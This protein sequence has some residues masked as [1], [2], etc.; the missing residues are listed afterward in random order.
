MSKAQPHE[1]SLIM[2][3]LVKHVLRPGCILLNHDRTP[4]PLCQGSGEWKPHQLNRSGLAK[5]QKLRKQVSAIWAFRLIGSRA[6]NTALRFS[7]RCAFLS[8]ESF[9]LSAAGGIRP[10]N[11]V[12][13]CHS[14]ES[15]QEI[16]CRGD[17]V[18]LK[19][20]LCTIPGEPSGHGSRLRRS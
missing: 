7:T 10:R 11:C 4:T 18:G 13:K 20:S 6:G 14:L 1:F 9:C 3:T 15:R 5:T 12:F 17:S 2:A 19:N 8:T 16:P